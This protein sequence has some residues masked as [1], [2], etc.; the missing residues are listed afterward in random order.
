MPARTGAVGV[1]PGFSGGHVQ[2]GQV[3][4]R[5]MRVVESSA[6][7][8][9]RRGDAP[10]VR[11]GRHQVVVGRFHGPGNLGRQG[12]GQNHVADG[13][14][15]L[16]EGAAVAQVDSGQLVLDRPGQLVEFEQKR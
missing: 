2:Q 4:G 3:L 6:T 12:C 11:G 8:L 5:Q 13:L 1:G 10:P 15:G 16:L 9:E 7:A 14:A